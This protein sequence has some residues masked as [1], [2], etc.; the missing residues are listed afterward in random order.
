MDKAN[1]QSKTKPR[2]KTTSV[3]IVVILQLNGMTEYIYEI[4]EANKRLD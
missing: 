4:L 2:Q 3:M 1:T